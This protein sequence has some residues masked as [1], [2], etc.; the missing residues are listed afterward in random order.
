M[1]ISSALK[2]AFKNTL[3]PPKKHKAF[4][5]H[6]GYRADEGDTRYSAVGGGSLLT[7]QKHWVSEVRRKGRVHC[8]RSMPHATMHPERHGSG[9]GLITEPFA[10][11]MVRKTH[12]S[13]KNMQFSVQVHRTWIFITGFLHYFSLMIRVASYYFSC[14]ILNCMAKRLLKKHEFNLWVCLHL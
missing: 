14:A 7:A 4:L 13:R 1:D 6:C 2:T 9:T 3:S 10:R 5:Q 12:L 11:V 8:T